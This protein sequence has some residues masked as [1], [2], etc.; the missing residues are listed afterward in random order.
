MSI[1]SWKHLRLHFSNAQF[2]SRY[3]TVRTAKDWYEQLS[4]R[5]AFGHGFMK[6]PGECFEVEMIDSMI[7]D[8]M[9]D[10]SGP[11]FDSIYVLDTAT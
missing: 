4:V 5:I 11:L 7:S 8:P 1:S 6:N 9:V 3:K 2:R 10:I